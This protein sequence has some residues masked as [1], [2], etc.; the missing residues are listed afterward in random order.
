MVGCASGL[1]A[2]AAVGAT[3]GFAADCASEYV[4]GRS[5]GA[6]LPVD[7][8]FGCAVCGATLGAFRGGET[9]MERILVDDAD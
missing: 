7:G 9:V 2:G 5:M 6:A 3:A 1:V 8:A 4:M